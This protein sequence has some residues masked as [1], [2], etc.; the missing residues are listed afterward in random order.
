MMMMMMMMMM[1]DLRFSETIEKRKPQSLGFSE[2][3]ENEDHKVQ[4]LE[5]QWKT[6][7]TGGGSVPSAAPNSDYRIM[8][9]L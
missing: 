3:I 5:K 6:N 7:T 8:I 4:G 9:V 2:T 1:M